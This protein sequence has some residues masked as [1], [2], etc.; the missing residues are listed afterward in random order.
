MILSVL[1]KI[2]GSLG[3]LKMKIREEK[4]EYSSKRSW[5]ATHTRAPQER[6]CPS[7]SSMPRQLERLRTTSVYQALVEGSPEV[8]IYL[9]SFHTSS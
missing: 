1:G 7:G 5:G 9:L 4:L 3:V 6:L 8:P 2:H